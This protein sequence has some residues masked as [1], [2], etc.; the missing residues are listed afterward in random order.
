MSAH[1][2]LSLLDGFALRQDG[3]LVGLPVGPERLL[4]FLALHSD[5]VLRPYVAG[6]LWPDTPERQAFANLRSCLWRLNRPGISVV[7]T[8]NHR[9]GLATSVYVDYRESAALTR[10]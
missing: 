6:S 9:L 1:V 10:L 7:E 3:R 8:Q 2:S 5:P 4:A